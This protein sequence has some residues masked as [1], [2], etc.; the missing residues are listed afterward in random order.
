MI[1][2]FFTIFITICLRE[3]VLMI[4]E[5][6]TLLFLLYCFNT[7]HVSTNSK[8]NCEKNGIV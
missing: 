6:V 3:Q 7:Y 5:I 1:T 2:I 8:K 4:N